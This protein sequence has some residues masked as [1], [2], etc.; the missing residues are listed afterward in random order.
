MRVRPRLTG[1]QSGTALRGSLRKFKEARRYKEAAHGILP[2]CAAADFQR[3][4]LR[5]GA[6][7]SDWLY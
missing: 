6:C 2:R 5:S 3:D 1:K 7:G 4:G